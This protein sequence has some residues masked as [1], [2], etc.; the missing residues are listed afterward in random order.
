[1]VDEQPWA[2]WGQE[3]AQLGG[4]CVRFTPPFHLPPAPEA[5][6]AARG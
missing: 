5:A 3:G 1:M 6:P 4:S 2:G